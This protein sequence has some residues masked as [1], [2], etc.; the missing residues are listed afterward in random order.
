MKA[1]RTPTRAAHSARHDTALLPPGDF[2][3]APGAIEHAPRKRRWLR[4][5]TVEALGRAVLTAAACLALAAAIGF[6]GGWLTA[7]GWLL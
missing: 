6:S 7:K 2:F 1:A 3:F 5:S 4:A